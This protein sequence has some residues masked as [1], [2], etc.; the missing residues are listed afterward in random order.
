M[1]QHLTFDLWIEQYK[2]IKNHIDEN[3]ACDGL[4]FE[5]YGAEVEYV[6]K[7]PENTIWT[8]VDC[9]GSLYLCSGW[10][11]VNRMNYFIT[12]VPYTNLEPATI[13]YE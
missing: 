2:P 8:L 4:M 7:Q 5:T 1:S 13:L 3:A 6:K 11:F 10:H 9:E 12:S